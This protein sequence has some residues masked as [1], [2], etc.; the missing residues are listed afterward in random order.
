MVKEIM[1]A[2][3]ETMLDIG[4][5][6]GKWGFLAREYLDIKANRIYPDQWTL[7]IDGIEIW[8]RYVKGFPWLSTIYNNIIVGDAC[9]EIDKLPDYDL[10]IVADV[11]EHMPK[12]DGGIL[13]RKCIRKAKKVCLL[14]I[15]L[16]DWTGNRI[17]DGNTYE[18]HISIWNIEE[19]NSL[20]ADEKA[21]KR[22][23]FA[24]WQ[25]NHRKAASCIIPIKK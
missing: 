25:S 13:L 22:G 21:E 23:V 10:I 2:K 11:I 1:D 15:P 17:L 9:K 12:H 3:P 7:K 18:S 6:F 20:I 19:L 8:E 24:E 14:S 5:G 4:I 16:G